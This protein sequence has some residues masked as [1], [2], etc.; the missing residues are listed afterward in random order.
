MFIWKVL[1]R[2]KEARLDVPRADVDAIQQLPDG[3]DVAER[4]GLDSRRI[5]MDDLQGRIGT[6]EEI[7]HMV[8]PTVAGH[9]HQVGLHGVVR[10]A[11]FPAS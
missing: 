11:H 1:L 2:A 6:L 7:E 3:G 4:E 9:P 5:E 8:L 10:D